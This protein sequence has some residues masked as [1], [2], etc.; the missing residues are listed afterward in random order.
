M[1]VLQHRRR[2]KILVA[3]LDTD[4]V[5]ASI[6]A[7]AIV[8]RIDVAASPPSALLALLADLLFSQD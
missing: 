8:L 4:G 7:M 2:R 1:F 6:G 5:V 3:A